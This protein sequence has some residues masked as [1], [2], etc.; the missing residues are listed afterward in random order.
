MR[1]EMI[2]LVQAALTEEGAG[3]DGLPT[4]APADY[5]NPTDDD[6]DDAATITHLLNR[7][8][9]LAGCTC[10]CKLGQGGERLVERDPYW[11]ADLAELVV[12]SAPHLVSSG[13]DTPAF[14]SVKL[15]TLRADVDEYNQICAWI[16][17]EN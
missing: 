13:G 7:A 16:Y 14:K 12:R 15:D 3:R 2:P 17:S 5:D 8:F 1:R 6:I 4:F 10:S 11:G 9:G